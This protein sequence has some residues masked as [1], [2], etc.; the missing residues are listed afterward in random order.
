MLGPDYNVNLFVPPAIDQAINA[1][2]LPDGI[3][4]ALPIEAR[5]PGFFH[6][7]TAQD[8]RVI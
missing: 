6:D 7:L 5:R 4:P 1:M 3:S 2:L 8:A